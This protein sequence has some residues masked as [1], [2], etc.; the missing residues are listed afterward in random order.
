MYYREGTD[1]SNDGRFLIRNHGD[2][3]TK[4]NKGGITF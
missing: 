3:T 2:E 1:D 4:Q